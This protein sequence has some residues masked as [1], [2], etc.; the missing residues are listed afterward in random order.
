MKLAY[1]ILH[2]CGRVTFSSLRYA[3]T[4]ASHRQY[5]AGDRRAAM[6]L[7]SC[8]EVRRFILRGSACCLKTPCAYPVTQSVFDVLR[9]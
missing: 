1:H 5:A 2:L 4:R 9:K 8:C 6:V 3:I 7:S